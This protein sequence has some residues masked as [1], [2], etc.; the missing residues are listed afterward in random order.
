MHTFFPTLRRGLR[1]LR[2]IGHCKGFGI[3][4]PFAFNLVTRVV[5]EKGEFYAYGP[6]SHTVDTAA[7]G[8]RL[9][10]ARLLLRLANDHQPRTVVAVG[11]HAQAALRYLEAGKPSAAAHLFTDYEPGSL[12]RHAARM[13]ALSGQGE[14]AA[15]GS[16]PG[17]RKLSHAPASNGP[18]AGEAATG[19]ATAAAQRPGYE[20]RPSGP[21]AGRADGTQAATGLSPV[22]TGL[23]PEFTALSPATHGNGA[24]GTA[25]TEA[26]APLGGVDLLYLEA[27]KGWDA[28]WSELLPYASDRTLFIVHGFHR[29]RADRAAWRRLTADGRVRVSFDLYD[30]GLAYF[31]RRLQRARYVVNYF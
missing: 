2:R 17:G 25:S 23:S 4:S 7:A 19:T 22:G 26:D 16:A 24:G 18:Q 13:A 10:D 20:A 11:R 12:T 27:Q 5:Y 30:F 8:L 31:D 14:H 15:Q 1:W 6:L 29:S 3:Q 9:R 21:H 28:A